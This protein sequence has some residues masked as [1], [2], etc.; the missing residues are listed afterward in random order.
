MGKYI[1]LYRKQSWM[2]RKRIKYN[3][4]IR[5]SQ[6]FGVFVL[7]LLLITSHSFIWQEFHKH[8]K[9]GIDTAHDWMCIADFFWL[10]WILTDMNFKCNDFIRLISFAGIPNRQKSLISILLLPHQLQC[11]FISVQCSDFPIAVFWFSMSSTL[12][13]I[14][15]QMSPECRRTKKSI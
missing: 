10:L 8:G 14:M 3:I 11:L 13:V 4:N 15:A 2:P 1:Y 9:H 7:L 12:A 5:K 6:H